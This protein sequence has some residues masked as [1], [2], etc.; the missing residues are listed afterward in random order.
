[1]ETEWRFLAHLCGGSLWGLTGVVTLRLALPDPVA[2]GGFGVA[3]ELREAKG[4]SG[5]GIVV[6]AMVPQGDTA[7]FASGAGSSGGGAR[8]SL[9]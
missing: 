1:M 3:W 8:V 6:F 2:R 9:E 4:S 7:A 5:Q